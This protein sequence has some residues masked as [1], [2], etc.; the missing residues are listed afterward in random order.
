MQH[1][2]I[3]ECKDDDWT[4]VT[5]A[6]VAGTAAAVGWSFYKHSGTKFKEMIQLDSKLL[7]ERITPEHFEE[8]ANNILANLKPNE[9]RSRVVVEGVTRSLRRLD[10]NQYKM[11]A[12]EKYFNQHL[13]DLNEGL[14][15][16]RTDEHQLVNVK[17]YLYANWKALPSYLR[18]DK[19][20]HQLKLYLNLPNQE[21]PI[22]NPNFMSTD[23]VKS[24]FFILPLQKKTVDSVIYKLQAFLVDMAVLSR[25]LKQHD[26]L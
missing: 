19:S 20:M 6:I 5:P 14:T 22:P 2:Q 1:C 11:K 18:E 4:N 15:H 9:P 12:L 23:P 25:D 8:E 13:E 24:S 26:N 17:N 3:D 21:F 7:S 16:T 10:A